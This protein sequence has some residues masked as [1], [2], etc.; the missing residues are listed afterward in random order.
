LNSSTPLPLCALMLLFS[1]P[2]EPAFGPFASVW[3]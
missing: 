1:Q 2:A 3:R